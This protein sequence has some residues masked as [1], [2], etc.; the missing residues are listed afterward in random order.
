MQHGLTSTRKHDFVLLDVFV[1]I[2]YLN[3][4]HSI[5]SENIRVQNLY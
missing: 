4:K 5:D 1:T 2:Q 3:I